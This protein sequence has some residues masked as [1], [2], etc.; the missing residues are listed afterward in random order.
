MSSVNVN[1]ITL[2][3]CGIANKMKREKNNAM[4]YQPKNRYNNVTGNALH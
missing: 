1:I 3:V 2:N 4:V